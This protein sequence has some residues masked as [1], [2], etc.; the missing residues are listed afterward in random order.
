LEYLEP[1]ECDNGSGKIFIVLALNS[2]KIG[3]VFQIPSKDLD[4]KNMKRM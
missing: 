1:D 2:S 3:K 4:R